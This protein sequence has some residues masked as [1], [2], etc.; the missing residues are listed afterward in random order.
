[1]IAYFSL[2]SVCGGVNTAGQTQSDCYESHPEPIII[3]LVVLETGTG[4]GSVSL[5][6]PEEPG[7]R[8]CDHLADIQVCYRLHIL[9]AMSST[10]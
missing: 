8:K 2:S 3:W 10:C 4:T 1:M 6:W 7:S 5:E 9:Q